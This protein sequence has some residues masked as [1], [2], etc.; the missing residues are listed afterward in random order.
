LK[1]INKR[2]FQDTIF[3][4]HELNGIKNAWQHGNSHGRR[5]S[6]VGI[7]M[8]LLIEALA[9]RWRRELARFL[10]AMM[11]AS[12]ALSA[13]ANLISP[14]VVHDDALSFTG[15]LDVTQFSVASF[16]FASSNWGIGVVEDFIGSEVLPNGFRITAQHLVAPDAG[17]LAPN[18]LLLV[19]IILANNFAPGGPPQGPVSTSVSHG[20]AVDVLQLSYI[21]ITISSS[22]L[23]INTIHEAAPARVPEPPTVYL[24]CVLAFIF[25]LV[26]RAT[27]YL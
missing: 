23:V 22:R 25:V 9:L 26:R 14:N 8:R 4:E 17:E 2:L 13:N 27:A 20:S 12:L 10:Y 7:A 1:T 5:R 21:P 16:A 18:P 6:Q 11:L 19:G 3:H 24:L 15:T